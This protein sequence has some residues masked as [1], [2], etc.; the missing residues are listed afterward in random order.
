MEKYAL[1]QTAGKE[2]FLEDEKTVVFGM[3][4]KYSKK[5]KSPFWKILGEI[6]IKIC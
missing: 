5:L 4:C 3:W 1:V 2:K 6:P